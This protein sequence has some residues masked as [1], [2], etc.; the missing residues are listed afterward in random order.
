M[1][2]ALDTTDYSNRKRV[3]EYWI[4]QI[5]AWGFTLLNTKHY[6]NKSAY[7]RVAR[8]TR[9]SEE[10]KE[11]IDILYRHGDNEHIAQTL[12]VSNELVRFY[13]NRTTI[14][15]RIKDVVVGYYKV[16]AK[17]VVEWYL[18]SQQQAETIS[19]QRK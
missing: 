7:P 8:N 2:E 6:V 1:I 16:R 17:V 15:K 3:E 4:Q 12:G 18:K 19:A 14:P 9:L 13:K 5:S 10:E 11:I